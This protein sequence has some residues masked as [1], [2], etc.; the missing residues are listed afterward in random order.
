MIR[1]LI[2]IVIGYVI[3][4]GAIFAFLFHKYAKYK[5]FIDGQK[6]G[7]ISQK[8]FKIANADG[9]TYEGIY[10]PSLGMW[11]IDE[12]EIQLK[13]KTR[14]KEHDIEI[15]KS[16]PFEAGMGCAIVAVLCIITCL[17]FSIAISDNS[18]KEKITVN[19]IK[20][21]EELENAGGNKKNLNMETISE[22]DKR[23]NLA[24]TIQ[25]GMRY[26]L[27]ID[28]DGEVK[29][30]TSD[31]GL[32][33][34]FSEWENIVSIA[35][36]SDI[37]LGLND[38]GMVCATKTESCPYSVDEVSDWNHIVQIDA[39]EAYAVGL[40]DSGHVWGV[41]RNEEGQLDFDEWRD[42]V[43]V[44]T[45]HRITVGLDSNN[46]LHFTGHHAEELQEEYERHIE[47]WIG[48]KSIYAS[49][50]N[51]KTE[52]GH[53]IGLKEDG[54]IVVLG[55]EFPSSDAKVDNLQNV[56]SLA[57]GDYH[58]V[59][60]TNNGQIVILGD[61]GTLEYPGMDK[62]EIIEDWPA[63]SIVEMTA[64]YYLTVVRDSNGEYYAA[65]NDKQ[66]QLKVNQW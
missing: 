29:I 26:V 3:A 13:K 45:G 20:Q 11:K 51:K 33:F 31:V 38:D 44:A 53:V 34:D 21:T 2:Y 57:L 47:E 60:V 25:A 40:D 41:G 28:S 36:M 37:V 24:T 63:N 52:M 48:I 23:R 65:G 5:I 12:T 22:D 43:Q 64:G 50:G 15:K 39:G 55:D 61:P 27:V 66:G 14:I 18:S 42:I 49:G 32:G 56:R 54:S 17:L 10:D 62:K 59:T 8:Q 1:G 6:V 35:A 58:L 30:S 19:D 46:M 9:I 16:F 4:G 7:I